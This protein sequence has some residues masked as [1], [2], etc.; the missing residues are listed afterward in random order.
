LIVIIFIPIEITTEGEGKTVLSNK[1]RNIQIFETSTVLNVH[2]KEHQSVKKDDLLIELNSKTLNN[3]LK[4]LEKLHIFYNMTEERILAI[5]ED[6]QP[7]FEQFT[8]DKVLIQTELNIYLQ[9]KNTFESKKNFMENQIFS[10]LEEENAVRHSIKLFE[11]LFD[12]AKSYLDRLEI[13]YKKNVIA[14][15]GKY[16]IHKQ[17]VDASSQVEMKKSSLKS[18]TNQR[19]AHEKDLESFISDFKRRNQLQLEKN[20]R[21]RD[22][23]K[24]EIKNVKERLKKTKIYAES[25]G[26]IFNLT[27][28][29]NSV[30]TPSQI[31]AQ[32]VPKNDLVEVESVMYKY[33]CGLIEVGEKSVIKL[34]AFPYQIYG[35][36]KGKV[37]SVSPVSSNDVQKYAGL[38]V[39]I[40]LEKNEIEASNR[41]IPLTPLMPLEVVITVDKITFAKY[42]WM[43]FSR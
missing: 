35:T 3:E 29:K 39:K 37:V 1:I 23:V 41:K 15:T 33:N 38:L 22:S 36:I 42:I 20:I 8:K 26:I 40:V 12:L 32:I 7:N 18:T 10:K 31:I 27:V 14:W 11:Q 21:N 9:E 34:K 43:Y 5:L 4:N 16:D 30:V 28:H 6:R 24:K 17:C 2:V 13:L 19:I 25:D